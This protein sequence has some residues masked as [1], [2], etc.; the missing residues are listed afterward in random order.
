MQNYIFDDYHIESL[1]DNNI[2]FTI[3]L[4][5]L[6]KASKSSH[7]AQ[8]IVVKLTKKQNMPF[9]SFVIDFNQKE[10]KTVTQ[11]KNKIKIKKKIKNKNNK[12]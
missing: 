8:N 9:F 2:A 7:S 6:I 11:V 1:N 12:K 10:F 4:D 5:N 3:S